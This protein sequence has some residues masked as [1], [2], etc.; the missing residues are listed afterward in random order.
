M[1]VALH[2][3]Q[4]PGTAAWAWLAE[5]NVEVPQVKT[6]AMTKDNRPCAETR[7]H[8]D[9]MG[10]TPVEVF[11]ELWSPNNPG[12]QLVKFPKRR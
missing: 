8:Y 4:G 1:G 10:F 11:P 5:R 6:I 9:S 7:E 2:G 12:L 3:R